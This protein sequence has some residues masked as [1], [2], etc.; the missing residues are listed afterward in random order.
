MK[1]I[2]LLLTRST[3]ILS[4][5][6]HFFTMDEYTHVAIS[7]DGTLQNWYS[8]SRK[9]WYAPLP[10]GFTKESTTAGG[11]LA[12][13]PWMKCALLSLSVSDET[14]AEINR[15]LDAMYEAADEYQYNILGVLLCAFGLEWRRRRHYF[16]SQFVGELLTTSGAVSLPKPAGLMHPDDYRTLSQLTLL[17]RGTVLGL[18]TR[19]TPQICLTPAKI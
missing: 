10:A 8:F 17:Y 18:A 5:M 6:I 14:Y 7:T 4:R 12:R 16:C 13:H 3:T 2:Y 19:C 11:Y 9:Q 15:R 1:T